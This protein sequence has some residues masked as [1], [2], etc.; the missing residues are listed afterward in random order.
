MTTSTELWQSNQDLAR[1]CLKHP[2]VQGIATGI[3]D[4]V[5]FSCYVGQ[6]AFFLEAFARA[7]SLA[8]V[9]A[10]DWEGFN[11]LFVPIA[12]QSLNS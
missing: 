1:A 3:L 4:H 5:K 6:D 12:L 10:P 2:F 9:K 11:T 8:A 7:Y